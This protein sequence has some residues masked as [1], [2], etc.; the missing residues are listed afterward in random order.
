MENEGIDVEM[1]NIELMRLPKNEFEQ[2]DVV[3]HCVNNS[4]LAQSQR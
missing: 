1:Q 3:C 4:R 2:T